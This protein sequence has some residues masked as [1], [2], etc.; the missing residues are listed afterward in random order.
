MQRQSHQTQ[1]I[2]APTLATAVLV[3]ACGAIASGAQLGGRKSPGPS[4]GPAGP[5]LG[6][7]GPGRGAGPGPGGPAMTQPS[8]QAQPAAQ[9]AQTQPT[10]PAPFT[11]VWYGQ[12]PDVWQHPQPYAEWRTS[13]IPPAVVINAFFAGTPPTN[14]AMAAV[15]SSEWLPLGV[16]TPPLAPGAVPTSFQQIAASKAGEVKG[17]MYDATTNATQPLTGHVD[18]ASRKVTWSVGTPGVMGFESTL[19]ELIKPAPTVTVVSAA[20]RQPG[21]LV[22]ASPPTTEPTPRAR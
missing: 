20:G 18:L 16:F 14:P 7:G 5:S 1:W 6:P 4:H 9:P 15:L 10:R 21:Q 12:H 8:H 13:S 17:V 22:L 11:P 2:I 19:D 3:A